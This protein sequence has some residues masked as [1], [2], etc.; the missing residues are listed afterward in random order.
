[1]LQAPR[2]TC[3]YHSSRAP[4]ITSSALSGLSLRLSSPIVGQWWPHWIAVGGRPHPPQTQPYTPIRAD[5][6]SA[7]MPRMPH[8]LPTVCLNNSALCGL[9]AGSMSS[10]DAGHNSFAKKAISKKTSHPWK[11]ARQSCHPVLLP[12]HIHS[13]YMLGDEATN[14]DEPLGM[15]IFR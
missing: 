2:M 1:M 6:Q 9:C 13:K 10:L 11:G 8:D 12:L 3:L 5:R 4:L 14:K 7:S 15:A